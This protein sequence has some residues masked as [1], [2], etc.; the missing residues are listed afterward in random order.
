MREKLTIDK[1]LRSL[2]EGETITSIL[3][4]GEK[5]FIAVRDEFGHIVKLYQLK[6][7]GT[8]EELD[9]DAIIEEIA[10][11][12]K[13][14]VNI[15]AFLKDVLAMQYELDLMELFY[16]I[17]KKPKVSD[18]EGCYALL[19]GGKRGKPFKLWLRE[20]W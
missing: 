11:Y 9:V 2:K 15:K 19:I 5:N 17:Q 3:E 20:P 7:D 10:E 8:L 6:D 16:R 4:R 18:E 12:L 14:K 13:D 1:L